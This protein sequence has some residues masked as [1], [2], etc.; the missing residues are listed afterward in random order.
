MVF[1]PLH[2]LW[3][4]RRPAQASARSVL[5]PAR[6]HWVVELLE[7]R[8]MLDG[9]GVNQIDDEVFSALL[10]AVD[11]AVDATDAD[12]TTSDFTD[13]GTGGDAGT[14]DVDG[15][16]IDDGTDDSSDTGNDESGDGETDDSGL[17]D[18][19]DVD[20]G[21]VNDGE[22]PSSIDDGATD[23]AGTGDPATDDGSADDGTADDGSTDNGSTDD[24]STDNGS[25]DVDPTVPPD[26]VVVCVDPRTSTPVIC[27][28]WNMPLTFTRVFKSG[29]EISTDDAETT[30]AVSDDGDGTTD[31]STD[32]GQTLS[33]PFEMFDLLYSSVPTTLDD[34][35]DST[36]DDQEPDQTGSDV[37]VDLGDGGDP[38]VADGGVVV[39]YFGGVHMDDTT[40]T[41][42]TLAASSGP[43]LGSDPV[44]AGP[45]AGEPVAFERSTT[46]VPA[47]SSTVAPSLPGFFIVSPTTKSVAPF[48]APPPPAWLY[49]LDAEVGD[50]TDAAAPPLDDTAWIAGTSDDA[51]D[52]AADDDAASGV[53]LSLDFQSADNDDLTT[54]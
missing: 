50:E 40:D 41:D 4:A 26:N 52:S 46:A 19:G 5:R 13:D 43:T 49:A 17:G 36:A 1:N 31:S 30:G 11:A 42:P 47:A 44:V 10:P 20:L 37:D 8:A 23:D 14:I 24:G 7:R 33:D 12:S 6:R 18:G 28:C 45:V 38:I 32:D 3:S 25:T 27:V 21:D 39:C 22:D 9:T 29:G 15:I 53:D 51:T 16:V 34:T 35:L 54:V 2:H 48:A